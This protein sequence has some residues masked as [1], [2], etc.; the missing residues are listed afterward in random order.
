ML[1]SAGAPFRMWNRS[2][3]SLKPCGFNSSAAGKLPFPRPLSPVLIEVGWSR[4]PDSNR[5][6]T[7]YKTVAL[8][9]ELRRHFIFPLGVAEN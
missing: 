6:P 7:V 2:L 5:R 9:A 4:L 3:R 8:P 1:K